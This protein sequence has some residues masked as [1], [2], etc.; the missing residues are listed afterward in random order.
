M[1]NEFKPYIALVNFARPAL[2][3]LQMVWDESAPS[4]LVTNKPARSIA[5][6]FTSFQAMS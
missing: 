5:A 4:H 1:C 3:G 6:Q 2:S